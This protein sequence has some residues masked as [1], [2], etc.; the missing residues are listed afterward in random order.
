MMKSHVSIFPGAIYKDIITSFDRLHMQHI[1][2]IP[3]F[4]WD[5]FSTIELSDKK[6]AFLQAVP[7]S[8]NERAFALEYGVDSLLSR[9]DDERVN[10]F[11]LE[12]R[13]VV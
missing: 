2:L 13:T 5:T 8:E 6:V 3:P 1:L 10:V 9:F 4:L 7:I 12:R 11:N